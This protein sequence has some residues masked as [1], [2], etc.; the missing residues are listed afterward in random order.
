[1]LEHIRV[2]S[3]KKSNS[4][5]KNIVYYVNTLCIVRIKEYKDYLLGNKRF[6]EVKNFRTPMA[7]LLKENKKNQG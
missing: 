5:V 1:M 2:N 7:E 4:N 3:V 6:W